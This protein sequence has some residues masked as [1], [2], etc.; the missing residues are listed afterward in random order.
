MR[1]GRPSPGGP[2]TAVGA[3]GSHAEFPSCLS[4]RLSPSLTHSSSGV[5]AVPTTSPGARPGSAPTWRPGTR[6]GRPLPA[7]CLV[8]PDALRGFGSGPSPGRGSVSPGPRPRLPAASS[9]GARR[10]AVQLGFGLG[11]LDYTSVGPSSRSMSFHFWAYL[12]CVVSGSFLRAGK[13][14]V[15]VLS[16]H[17]RKCLSLSLALFWDLI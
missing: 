11:S 1:K 2:L 8:L 15:C 17:L 10:C 13:G 7:L 12:K 9:S 16:V 4:H 5:D 14:E 6:L 3:G